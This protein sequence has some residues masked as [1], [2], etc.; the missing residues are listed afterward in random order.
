MTPMPP[1]SA[2]AA[3]SGASEMRTAMPPWM[4]GRRAVTVAD[5]EAGMSTC[6]GPPRGARACR[7]ATPRR[8]VT[9][10]R[11]VSDYV[12]GDVGDGVADGLDLLGLLVGDRDAELLLE[13]HDELDD[14]ERVGAEVVDERGLLGDVVLLDVELLDDDC[15]RPSR[16]SLRV[17]LCATPP[18]PRGDSPSDVRG[19]LD[20]RHASVDREHLS[21]DVARVL[22]REERDRSGDVVGRCRSARAR[23]GP[24]AASQTVSES[25]AVMS[26]SMKPGA[27]ALARTL[28]DASSRATDFVRPMTPALAAA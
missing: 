4:I 18:S 20:E 22:G 13:R 10:R 15:L 17:P 5:C 9:G 7:P 14:V 27:T 8:G 6:G 25:S 23:S 2:T 21:G 19:T 24:S 28:R 16:R 26:V 1:A 12:L 3:A 11:R